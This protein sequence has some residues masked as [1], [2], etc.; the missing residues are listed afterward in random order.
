VGG[1]KVAGTKAEELA[2]RYVAAHSRCQ[3]DAVLALFADDAVLEDP[4]GS[5]PLRGM[6]AIRSFFESTHRRNGRLR[7]ERVGPVL[8]CGME[9]SWHIRAGAEKADFEPMLDVIYTLRCRD[10][11]RVAELR[12]YFEMGRS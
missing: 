10:D 4:V 1:E 6:D 12:A 9:A 2:E 11:G 7:I 3:L 8:V 5:E